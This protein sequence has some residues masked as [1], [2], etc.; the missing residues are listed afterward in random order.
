[1]AVFA[2]VIAIWLQG[3]GQKWVSETEAAIAFN[4][5]PVWTALFALV[6]LGQVLSVVQF[7]GA[8]L[9]VGSLTVLSWW[10]GKKSRAPADIG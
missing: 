7:I 2:Q 3:W 6:V 8:S 10:S 1:M 4:T 9:V 5:E